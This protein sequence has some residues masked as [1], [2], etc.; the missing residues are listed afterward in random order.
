[1]GIRKATFEHTNPPINWIHLDNPSKR[2]LDSRLGSFNIRLPLRDG[3]QSRAAF[4]RY[5]NF[6]YLR[7]FKLNPDDIDRSEL[8]TIAIHL[9]V[10]DT[11]IVSWSMD[12]SVAQDF[13][14]T[15]S[16]LLSHPGLIQSSNH[17]AFYVVDDLLEA[18][19]PFFD[20]F[21]DRVAHIEH[22]TLH[23]NHGTHIKEEIF[24]LKR[25]TMQVRRILS[26]QRDVA[27]QL[28]RYWSGEASMDAIY[29]FELYDHVIRLSDTADTYRE[30]MDTILD[31][32]L[33]SVSNRLN[34]I[35]KTLTIVTALFMPTSVIAAL[36]GMNFRDI[37][38]ADNPWGFYMVIGTVVVISTLLLWIFK[39]RKWI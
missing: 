38:G 5:P 34:E 32:Y 30:M 3:K 21:N 16:K 12:P 18:T 23:E 17:L 11:S 22:Q 36:Y 33:S 31:I 26:S 25:M 10:T 6:F 2:E 39:R 37:P 35:V 8:E 1:M 9:V 4:D 27:Y 19:F 13:E 29:S 7:V 14:E 28:A 24:R 20:E 15:R